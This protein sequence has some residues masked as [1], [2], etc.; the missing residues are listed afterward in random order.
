[1]ARKKKQET[2]LEV[3]TTEVVIDNNE[4]V[5]KDNPDVSY[6]EETSTLSIKKDG[7]TV[8]IICPEQLSSEYTQIVNKFIPVEQSV[9]VGKYNI[10]SQSVIDDL[11]KVEDNSLEIVHCYNLFKESKNH[12]ETME[13]L[14]NKL[15]TGTQ[16]FIAD[17]TVDLRTLMNN[18]RLWIKFANYGFK[19]FNHNYWF[20]HKN[21]SIALIGKVA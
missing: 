13:L 21:V 7:K 1:M 6:C 5:I 3:D 11:N 15:K 19:I 20:E 2:V 4:E 12:E 16:C 10:N 17:D 14:L 9:S 8:D 18:R